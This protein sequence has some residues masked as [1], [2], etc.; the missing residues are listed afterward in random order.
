LSELQSEHFDVLIV[1][2]GIS[3]LGSAYHL[4]QQCPDKTFVVLEAKPTFGGTWH[5]HKFPGIRSDSDLYTY[6]FRFKPWL[7]VPIATGE[8]INAYLGEVITENDLGRHIRYRHTIS[9]ASWSSETNLWTIEATLGETGE[10]RRFT[11]G[12]L[13][14]CQGYY[15]HSEGYTPDW[16]GKDTFKGQIVHP[17]TWPEGLDYT[18]KR[19]V[20]I[21][22]GATAATIVPALAKQAGHVTMLQRSPTY[23]FPMRNAQQLADDLRVLQIDER[24]VHEILRRRNLLEQHVF[25]GR[26]RKEPERAKAELLHVARAFFP[27]DFEF[28][29][30]FVPSYRPWQQR[31]CFVPDGD[32]F[33]TIAEGRATIVTDQIES[34]T[35]D[36]ILLKSGETLIADLVVTATG[37]KLSGQGDIDLVVDGT[38]IKL[39]DK[40][41]YHGM[42]FTEVPNLAWIFGYWRQAWTLRVDLIGDFICRLLKHMDQRGARRVTPMLRAED[43]DMPIGPWVTPESFSSGYL[44]RQQ[45]LLPKTGNKPEWQHTQDYWKERETLPK[46]NLDEILIYDRPPA[47]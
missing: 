1:G 29:K 31:I 2:A 6:G 34:F 4:K 17:Q 27:K 44:M 24:W 19:V 30:H 7:G 12:F 38:S 8:E 23:Y 33:K 41:A 20:V 36:G 16:P 21:G 9:R 5:T 37:L 45:H 22:S 42:M 25:Q 47:K 14:M 39:S 13:W 10:L 26:C 18:G 3:G 11:A 46:I 32:L 28:E 43:A 35:P 40:I 15:R